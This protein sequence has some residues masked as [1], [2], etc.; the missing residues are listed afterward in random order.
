MIIG[1]TSCLFLVLYIIDELSYDSF[2]AE[3]EHVYR[4]VTNITEVD[5][6]FTWAV[7]QTPFAPTVKKDYPEV[8]KYARISGAGR[9]MFEKG[10]ENIIFEYKAVKL[11]YHLAY[12]FSINGC[13]WH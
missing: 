13:I 1:I 12:I 11:T 5:N 7:A 3:G 10:A 2:H 9:M 6:E 8:E 4:V